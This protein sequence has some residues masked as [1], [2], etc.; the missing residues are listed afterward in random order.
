MDIQGFFTKK[1]LL[2]A[3]KLAAGSTLKITRVCAG[4]AE[5][6]L[7]ASALSQ[8]RQTPTVGTARRSGATVILPVTLEAGAAGSAYTLRE[9]GVYAQDPDEGEILYKVYRLSEPVEIRPSSRLVLRFYLEETVSQ[10]LNVTVVRASAGLLTE[11][12]LDPLRSRVEAVR[13]PSR[14]VEL[15]GADLPDYIARL[16]RLLTEHLTLRVKGSLTAGRLLI[17]GFYGP[18]S[19]TVRAGADGDAVLKTET[20]VTRCAVPVTFRD[21]RFQD[22]RPGDEDLRNGI[23]VKMGLATVTDCSF[24]SDDRGGDVIHC[25]RAISTDAGGRVIVNGLRAMNCGIVILAVYGGTAVCQ[26]GGEE[27]VHD[28]AVGVY[29]WR[30]GLVMLTGGTPDTLGAAGNVRD[31]GG[32]IVSASGE[33]L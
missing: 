4:A 1:G 30:G 11:A 26:A 32:L 23:T 18:G 6:A 21:I 25:Y 19:L 33:L 29:T 3:A 27:A 22:P 20:T 17:A 14:A 12:D 15:P 5:T 9:L 7:T 10:D 31:N 8:I 13:V 28:N 16:P 24:S 2:L